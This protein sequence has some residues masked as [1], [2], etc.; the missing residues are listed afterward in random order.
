MLQVWK[1]EENFAELLFSISSLAT[2]GFKYL[3][4][5]EIFSNN[6]ENHRKTILRFKFKVSPDQIVDSREKS[7]RFIN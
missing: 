7:M 2:H 5:H 3:P 1:L 4:A 6:A